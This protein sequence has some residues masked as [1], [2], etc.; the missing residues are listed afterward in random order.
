MS[1]YSAFMTCLIGCQWRNLTSS[2]MYVYDSWKNTSC[3]ECLNERVSSLGIFER[4]GSIVP[5]VTG[6]HT[7]TITKSAYLNQVNQVE[8]W[9]SGDLYWNIWVNY[10]AMYNLVAGSRYQ[11]L[12]REIEPT[13]ST[14]GK[15]LSIIADPPVTWWQCHLTSVPIRPCVTPTPQ[16]LNAL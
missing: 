8:F 16:C 1:V 5:I 13:G 10:T 4:R 7:F 12:L 3:C 11:F 14:Q 6:N 15:F 2:N 9:L